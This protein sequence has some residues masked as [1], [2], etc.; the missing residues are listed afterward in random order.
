M[1]K[2]PKGGRTTA[3]SRGGGEADM[4][5]KGGGGNRKARVRVGL[6]GLGRLLKE[7]DG[8]GE[9][10]QARFHE[11]LGNRD[12]TVVMS[13]TLAGK[14]KDFAKANGIQPRPG[15]PGQTLAKRNNDNC[16]PRTDPWC[17][18]I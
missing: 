3:V 9:N 17:I 11:M 14:I 2:A 13:P 12:V 4:A 1:A 7:I 16:D 6:H 10:V 5:A 15:A 18:D 8:R